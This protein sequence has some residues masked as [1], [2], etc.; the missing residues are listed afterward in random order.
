MGRLGCLGVVSDS[1]RGER[2][3]HSV[4]FI[5]SKT[6]ENKEFAS[7][8]FVDAEVGKHHWSRS[9]TSPQGKKELDSKEPNMKDLR[10]P[11]CF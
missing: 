4:W 2:G 11:Q 8:S 7:G 10:R 6:C 1:C 3:S 5:F 9:A